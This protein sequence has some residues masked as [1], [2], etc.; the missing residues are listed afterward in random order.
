VGTGPGTQP[1]DHGLPTARCDTYLARLPDLRG[2]HADLL[3]DSERHRSAH[4]RLP[5]D[6][7]RF[8]LGAALLRIAAGLRLRAAPSAVVVD[9][10]CDDC[11]RPHGKPRLPGT[12]LHASVSHSGNVVLVS[13]TGVGPVGVDVEVIRTLDLGAIAAYTCT[14][15]EQQ[16]VRGLADFFAYWTRKESVLKATGEGLRR[17]MT[18]VFVAEPDTPPALLGLAGGPP[19]ACQMADLPA[20]PGYVAAV[21]VLAAQ[22]MAFD[23]LQAG[24][25]LAVPD[26]GAGRAPASRAN[27]HADVPP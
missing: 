27:R 24:P 1:P 21:A 22:P 6:R 8:V 7:D 25:L 10:A 11:G 15:T 3:D 16:H 23:L 18:D 2:A 14:A 4:F 9:R 20:G 26:S 5:A 17:P 12:D 19:P 13:L